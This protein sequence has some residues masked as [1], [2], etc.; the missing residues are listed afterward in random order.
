MLG[1][2]VVTERERGGREGGRRVLV[3][4]EKETETKKKFPDL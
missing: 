4:K 2:N 1:E 3:M